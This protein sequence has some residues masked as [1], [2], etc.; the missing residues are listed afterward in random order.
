[1]SETSSTAPLRTRLSPRILPV[2]PGFGR[3]REISDLLGNRLR[4]HAFEAVDCPTW[5]RRFT[6]DVFRALDERRFFPVYRMADGEFSFA[7]GSHEEFLPLRKAGPRLALKRAWKWVTGRHGQHMSG[8]P[9][10]GWEVYTPAERR[11]LMDRYGADL[12]F[13]AQHGYLALALDESPFFAH[14]LPYILDW[15]DRH[16]VYLHAGNYTH[17]YSVYVLL[18]GPDRERLLRGRSVLVV[19]AMDDA[20]SAAIDAVLRRAGAARTQ[21]IPISREKAMLER[22]DLRAVEG[23]VDLALVG[24]GVG[25]ANVLRQLQPLDAVSLDA[26]FALD[27]MADP[28]YRWRR[29]FCVPDAEFDLE[30]AGF[31]TEDERRR[32]REHAAPADGAPRG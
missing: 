9:G 2:Y 29:P 17:M 10:Y 6:D 14:Y 26:G 23:R 27:I 15:F 21:F 13:V 1:M 25:A 16:G 18:N 5:Y 19:N 24:A 30:R 4:V 32:V 11:T 22:L 20:R 8:S 31:L 7:L 3:H 12:A 28:S